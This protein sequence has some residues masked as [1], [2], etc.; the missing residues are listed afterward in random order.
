MITPLCVAGDHLLV[1]AGQ[2]VERQAVIGVLVPA[3]DGQLEFVQFDDQPPFG[4]LGGRERGKRLGVV[5]VGAGPGQRA[6]CCTA[7]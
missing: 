5:V 4:L 6:R 2:Q 7:S 1:L 3:D